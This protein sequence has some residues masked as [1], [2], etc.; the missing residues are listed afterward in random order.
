M[1][2][3]RPLLLD[4]EIGKKRHPSASRKER[5][6]RRKNKPAAATV[7]DAGPWLLEESLTARLS[8]DPTKSLGAAQRDVGRER[9]KKRERGSGRCGAGS[10]ETVHY[11]MGKLGTGGEFLLWE[12]GAQPGCVDHGSCADVKH[13]WKN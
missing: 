12:L 4:W 1:Y 2:S 6:G 7:A 8:L 10:G 9:K 3:S 13:Q 11:Q 5:V